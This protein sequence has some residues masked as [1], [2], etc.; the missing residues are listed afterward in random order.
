[1]SSLPSPLWTTRTTEVNMTGTWRSQLPNYLNT[2]SPCHNACPVNGNIA[3]WIQQVKAQDYQ[4]AWLTLMDNNPFPAI[5]GR[6]CHHPCET[7]CNRKDLDEPIAICSLE[8]FVGDMA[9]EQ[10]WAIP[11]SAEQKSQ[12]V[13][14]VGGGPSGLSAAYQLKRRGY[15]VTLFEAQPSLGGLMRYGIPSYRLSDAVLDGE[16]QRILD[17]GVEVQS[18]TGA[19]DIERVKALKSEFD[20]VYLAIGAK[21]SKKLPI[22]DY[23]QSWVIDS[24]EFLA[25]TNSGVEISMGAHLV[26]IGGGSAAMDVA[27]TARRLG[28]EVTVLSL[29]SEAM[30]PAQREEVVEAQEESVRFETGAMLQS[31]AADASGELTLNCIRVEFEAGAVRGQFKVSPIPG[32][33]FSL[34]ANVIVPAL[35][36]EVEMEHWTQLSNGQGPVVA[37]DAQYQTAIPGVFAGGDF[38]SLDRFVTQAVGM[39][40]RAA[41]A[42][43]RYLNSDTTSAATTKQEVPFK[44]INT[45]YH[46]LDARQKQGHEAIEDRLDNFVEVQ[47]S[48]DEAQA[49]SEA[50]RCFSC[51][52]CI[53]CDN[54]YYYCP[55]MAITKLERGYEVKTDYC[56]GCGL[57]AAECPTG[58]IIMKEEV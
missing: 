53:F 27:R 44:A 18:G 39:G 14:I 29:E 33:E 46:P 56:K 19:L 16:I 49:V 23:D 45:Y 34:T 58:T 3:T 55:D 47:R 31:V 1:M 41:Q 28:K 38:A 43:V 9:L 37:I 30:M 5:A 20:A 57:C 22:L 15:Q 25:K 24:A 36:Q 50:S 12:K 8:R 51:G 32:S 13:A 42:I 48:L 52:N 54:C 7:P 11:P 4:G 35:G 21:R 40:K 17:L 6:I 10:Q 2:P 26:V